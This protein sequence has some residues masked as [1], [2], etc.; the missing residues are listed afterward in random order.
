MPAQDIGRKPELRGRQVPVQR[1]TPRSPHVPHAAHVPSSGDLD[2]EAMAPQQLLT[3]QRS[4]GNAASTLVLQRAKKLTQKQKREREAAEK[5]ELEAA[6]PQ[7]DQETQAVLG[8]SHWREKAQKAGVGPTAMKGDNPSTGAERSLDE[9]LVKI[10]PELLEELAKTEETGRLKLYRTMDRDEADAIL[11]WRGKREATEKWVEQQRDRK[12]SDGSPDPDVSK[13]YHAETGKDDA[14]VGT[15]PV[16]N[17]VGDWEQADIYYK[18]K[19]LKPKTTLE[20]TLKEGA[21]T[22]LFSPAHAAARGDSGAVGDMRG[23]FKKQG[24]ELPTSAGGEGGLAGYIGVKQ[25]KKGPFSLS[26]GKSEATQMLFQLFVEEV[27]DLYPQ[28]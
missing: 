16:K 18:K 11:A 21:H 1:P 13:E 9:I 27:R 20:F 5:A 17:H 6:A 24:K 26:V 23:Y 7:R 22:H 12:K 4:A 2:H 19:S 10:G 28:A 15:M 14:T 25:E 8:A 3:L